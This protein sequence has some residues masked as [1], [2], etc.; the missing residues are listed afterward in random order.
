MGVVAPL[1]FREVTAATR[2]LRRRGAALASPA[3]QLELLDSLPLGDASL[4]FSVC[5]GNVLNRVTGSRV[6]SLV[7]ETLTF[8]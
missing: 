2:S 8:R 4:A 5:F 3:R 6:P 1:E 7:G